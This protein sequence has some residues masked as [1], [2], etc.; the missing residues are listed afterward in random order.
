M[1][2]EYIRRDLFKPFSS[3][4]TGGF[5]VG[6]FEARALAQGMGGSIEVESKPGVGTRFT[7]RLPLASREGMKGEAA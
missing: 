4:K 1:T 3:S 7:L 5:G 6:A 2:A